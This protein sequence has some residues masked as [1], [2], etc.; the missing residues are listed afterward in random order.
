MV[1]IRGKRQKRKP[2]EFDIIHV[3]YAK[4]APEFIYDDLKISQKEL[5]EWAKETMVDNC[6]Y[7][8]QFMEDGVILVKTVSF[9]NPDHAALFRISFV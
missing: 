5:I 6:F 7:S 3:M 2:D 8:G 4:T 1:N 9:H